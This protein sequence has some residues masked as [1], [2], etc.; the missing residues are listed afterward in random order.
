MKLIKKLFSVSLILLI[1]TLVYGQ[2]EPGFSYQAIARTADGVPLVKTDIS[3]RFSIHLVN[4]EGVLIWQEDHDVQTSPLG[5]FTSV[6]GGEGGSTIQTVPLARHAD[7]AKH[8]AGKA[9][10]SAD[11]NVFL[12][13]QAGMNNTT[14][15]SNI[16]FG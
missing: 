4:L 2:S 1:S 12:G 5:L 10:T 15:G 13:Y 14:G 6:I 9:T 8:S 3:V 16:L 7:M 11:Y